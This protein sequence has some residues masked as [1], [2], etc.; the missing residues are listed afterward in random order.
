MRS[1]F[2]K[3]F[4]LL[5]TLLFLNG[6]NT[7]RG[8]KPVEYTDINSCFG[9]FQNILGFSGKDGEAY[10]YLSSYTGP[11]PKVK[12][13]YTPDNARKYLEHCA[14]NPKTTSLYY[15]PIFATCSFDDQLPIGIQDL[16]RTHNRNCKDFGL[17]KNRAFKLLDKYVELN[18][19]NENNLR[20]N[21]SIDYL[22]RY[23]ASPGNILIIRSN[24]FTYGDFT[25]DFTNNIYLKVMSVYIDNDPYSINHKHLIN[26]AIKVYGLNS[27]Y[28]E[29]QNLLDK[30]NVEV[31][32]RKLFNEAIAIS[33]DFSPKENEIVLYT[34]LS[35]S[36]MVNMQGY[37]Y[38]GECK[39]GKAHGNGKA[40]KS[41]KS[42]MISG[43]FEN[44][45]IKS[46]KLY[47]NGALTFEGKFKS[48]KPFGKGI[49]FYG[50]NKEKCQ[51]INNK[52]IDPIHIARVK[53]NELRREIEANKFCR[54]MPYPTETLKDFLSSMES[55]CKSKFDR[56]YSYVR[57]FNV[58]RSPWDDDTLESR[59]DSLRSC[60][61]RKRDKFDDIE[62]KYYQV[63]N[64]LIRHN[65]STSDLAYQDKVNFEE[66]LELA[67]DADK[68]L[69]KARKSAQDVMKQLDE[70]HK[71]YNREQD[72]QYAR[73][74]KNMSPWGSSSFSAGSSTLDKMY[75]K[76]QAWLQKDS[77]RRLDNWGDKKRQQQKQ[78]NAMVHDRQA[79]ASNI[80]TSSNYK[81][82][83]TASSY[84]PPTI[85]D[86]QYTS[87]MPAQRKESS[88]SETNV[89]NQN[90][91]INV[92][93]DNKR[94]HASNVIEYIEVLE[95]VS[96]VQE[97]SKL[98]KQF[99]SHG[100][101]QKTSMDT[102]EVVL[103]RNHCDNYRQ[104]QVLSGSEYKAWI[105][106]CGRPIGPSEYDVAN[107]R[108]LGVIGGRLVYKCIQG[109]GY[110][111]LKSCT[112]N[113]RQ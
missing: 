107:K 53:E 26:Y 55:V 42:T 113:R 1:I 67:K 94:Q 88:Q 78:I 91:S 29:Y 73:D 9:A 36:C 65:C 47:N 41:D 5:F 28:Q 52:R 102:L 4:S 37:L 99:K 18:V 74:I 22:K 3:T 108:S 48:N 2:L 111:D 34:S 86:R 70:A 97:S 21:N 17:D 11:E 60:L 80:S 50:G 82:R 54:S 64:E 79:S 103:S 14:L 90:K 89:S 10:G 69:K 13:N 81:K 96:Y 62:A 84:S 106:L 56:F 93:D 33:E 83:T 12:G 43:I 87:S 98:E 7:L 51:Y 39:N 23:P 24:K 44:G 76:Q 20:I 104:K 8:A 95:A 45:I 85:S 66:G 19:T 72:R 46:G 32:I 68:E 27:T 63:S 35:G 59:K 31:D 75:L 112:E 58:K 100:P 49:C 109:K 92:L 77:K 101:L 25:L 61:G 6:C 105:Y 16:A 38:E 30:S 110:V 40:N 71:E 57:N 15:A